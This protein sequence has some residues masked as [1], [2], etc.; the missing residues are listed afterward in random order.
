MRMAA[1]MF[2]SPAG[3]RHGLGALGAA[4]AGLLMGLVGA[5][6]AADRPSAEATAP[7]TARAAL[8][9][10]LQS[11]VGRPVAP[12]AAGGAGTHQAAP[13][14]AGAPTAVSPAGATG[15]RMSISV[16]RGQ[17]LDTLIRRHL[18]D[19]PLRLDLLRELIKQLNPTAFA[20]GS[21]HRLLAGARLQLPNHDDQM[22]YAFSDRL[23]SWA[24]SMRED[25]A[26]TAAGGF[27]PAAA[28]RKG[29]VR[30]P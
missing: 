17:A 8:E 2:R 24:A 20:P 11:P 7:P 15:P 16:E 29:W 1:T 6:A 21:G 13:G 23:A 18:S 19:S 30:Y 22:R 14:A 25:K 12:S 5:A 3:S 27:G 10:L 4:V 9:T 26:D 28:A